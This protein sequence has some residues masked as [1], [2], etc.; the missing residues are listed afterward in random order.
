MYQQGATSQKSAD[1]LN[2]T[3][4]NYLNSYIDKPEDWQSVSLRQQ[5]VN[6]SDRIVKHWHNL[7]NTVFSSHRN[8]S[9]GVT[10]LYYTKYK[11]SVRP[12]YFSK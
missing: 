6:N 1:R 3:I 12:T 8:G 10:N 5:V 2:P 11:I 7:S 9:P 4:F